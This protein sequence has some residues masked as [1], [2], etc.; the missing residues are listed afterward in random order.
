M[1]QVNGRKYC[2]LLCDTNI[3]SGF[4]KHENTVRKGLID[5]MLNKN[6]FL[7]ITF[8]G[9]TELFKSESL[10]N[11]LFNYMNIVPIFL[12]KNFNQ[13]LEE[14]IKNYPNDIKLNPVLFLFKAFKGKEYYENV[15]KLFYSDI[16]KNRLDEENDVSYKE[17]ILQDLLK[18]IKGYPKP[19]NGYSI[20]DIERWVELTLYKRLNEVNKNFVEGSKIKLNHNYFLSSKMI[21][22]MVFYKFYLSNKNPIVSDLGDILMSANFPYVDAI[23]VE[24]NVK[25]IVR[26]IQVK[27]KF[28]SNLILYDIND[29][30]PI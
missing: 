14:E 23:I 12:L 24:K 17:E 9:L 13:L 6:Y 19:K 1:V 20:K 7:C 29:I 10:F 4:L 21:S 28:V 30:L 25:E 8:T 15:K 22:Y 5:L 11:D 2:Y 26:Q 18:W 3:F 27:H 16:V